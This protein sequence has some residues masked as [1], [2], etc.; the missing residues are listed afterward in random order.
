VLPVPARIGRGDGGTGAARHLHFETK[1]DNVA[2]GGALAAIIYNNGT[3][4]P[5]T[6][7]GQTVGA[8]TLPAMFV[9]QADG[10]DLAARVAAS[11]GLPATLDFAAPPPSP[12]ARI[13]PASPSAVPASAAP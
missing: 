1:I 8:A 6:L 10:A 3:A 4:S 7:Y 5:F 2:A 13:S 9:N 11:P 12:P